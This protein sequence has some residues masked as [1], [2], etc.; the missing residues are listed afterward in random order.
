MKIRSFVR[1]LPLAA[2][3]AFSASAARSAD[4]GADISRKGV[5]PKVAELVKAVSDYLIGLRKFSVD[6]SSVMRMTAEG[7]KQEFVSDTALA[8]ERPRKVSMVLKS[9]MMGASIVCDGERV[10]TYL[11][12]LGKYT[13]EKA[14]E[15]IE[16]LPLGMGNEGIPIVKC[17]ASSDPA[18]EMMEGVVAASYAG[19]ERIGALDCHHLKFEQL[20]INWEMWVDSGTKPL[21]VKVV[22]DLGK[23]MD[24]LKDTLG[25]SG[26]GGMF[27]KMKYDASIELKNWKTDEDLPEGTFKFS[28][29]AG[30]Q[31]SES[32]FE[33]DKGGGKGEMQDM[34]GKA[35]PDFTLEK[36]GGAQFKLSDCKGKI[37]VLDFWATWCPPCKKSLPV[38][39]KA[40][41]PYKSKGVVF[42]TVNQ[43]E[44]KEKVKAF[45]EKQ[46]LDFDVVI[47][48]DSKI[49]DLYAVD[50][51]PRTF[52]ISGDGTIQA[53]HAGF[54]SNL[55][56]KLRKDL[57]RMLGGEKLFVPKNG[58]AGNSAE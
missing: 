19:I 27:K 10:F 17:I 13:E 55:A 20:D 31:K 23:M 40:L 47:D 11:P 42:M 54:V 14:P 2:V 4:E 52:L 48:A 26:D 53:I 16:S 12:S 24:S 30:A 41:E 9:G 57:D 6:I 21:I 29:P 36:L 38:I 37:V 44:D 8:V 35:A 3:L 45:L 39:I 28:P 18:K 25:G 5:D 1:I 34:L 22:P 33:A 50:S 51:I 49:S 32:F 15:S 58:G 43:G 56:D 46:K 7:M